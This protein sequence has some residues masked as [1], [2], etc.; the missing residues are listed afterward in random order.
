MAPV[1]SGPTGDASV[2]EGDGPHTYNF[3]FTD[4]GDD[5][6]TPSASCGTNGTLSE[7]ALDS[8][9]LTTATKTGSFKCAWSD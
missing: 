8:A 9:S 5:T 3:S 6:W 1:I 4:P 2:N 7:L